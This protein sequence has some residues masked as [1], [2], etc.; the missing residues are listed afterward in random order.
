MAEAR[1]VSRR[2]AA[3]CLIGV[4]E[5]G[6]FGNRF[7]EPVLGFTGFRREDNHRNRTRRLL[8]LLRVLHRFSLFLPAS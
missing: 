4:G 8:E 6:I 1:R 7:S 2:K 3:R 5:D